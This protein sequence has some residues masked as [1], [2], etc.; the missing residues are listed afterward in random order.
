MKSLADRTYTSQ[1]ISPPVLVS[2]SVRE[3]ETLQQHMSRFTDLGFEIEFFGGREYAIRAVPDNLFGLQDEKLFL[4]LLD[5]LS[6]ESGV[7]AG[8]AVH[9]KVASMSCKAAV[10]GKMSLS[11][12]EANALIDE[13]LT[14]DNPYACPHGRPTII[15]M[16]RYELEKKFKR[17]V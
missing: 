2:L 1:Q 10:K 12:A 11:F 8:R 4:D 7:G 6:E 15:S 16:S 3:Q 5:S 9:E 13:L 17:I 14:L